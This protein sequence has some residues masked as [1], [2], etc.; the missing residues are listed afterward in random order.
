[1]SDSSS[2]RG[3]IEIQI[4]TYVEIPLVVTEEETLS[5]IKTR[6]AD[7]EQRLQQIDERA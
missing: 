7:L 5:Y 4:E 6:I 3:K 2:E 1:M